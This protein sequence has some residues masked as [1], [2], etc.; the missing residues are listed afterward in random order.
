MLKCPHNFPFIYCSACRYDDYDE[1]KEMEKRWISNQQE[2]SD[3]S[4]STQ[5]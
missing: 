5:E 1:I 2:K 3:T 4:Q